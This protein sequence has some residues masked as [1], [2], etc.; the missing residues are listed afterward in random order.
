VAEENAWRG[1]AERLL[2]H[3]Y[4]GGPEIAVEVVLGGIPGDVAAPIPI[5]HSW[6]VVGSSLRR[7]DFGHPAQML[8]VVIDAEGTAASAIEEFAAAAP[9]AGWRPR[10]EQGP[11]RGGFVSG[12][13][14]DARSYE[15]GDV[16]LRVVAIQRPGMPVDIR[17]HANTE[18]IP[19]SRRA[20][21][22]IPEAAAH[23][24]TLRAPPG[25]RLGSGGGSG[26]DDHYQQDATIDTELRVAGLHRH[27]AGQLEAVGWHSL[28]QGGDDRA[29]WSTWALP[30]EQWQGLLLV[31]NAF[32]GRRSTLLL[33]VEA[34][35][36][37]HGDGNSF[38]IVSSM[39]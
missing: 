37:R 31:L 15:R 13:D 30:D 21:H 27:F 3:G 34:A 8:D 7:M 24:P 35:N 2:N 16:V 12:T 32:A 33:R 17:I 6:R 36:H 10:E 5:P 23:L 18:E 20:P 25:T 22:G 1:L 9:S 26:S 19:R 38:G 29:A 28:H 14:G 11:V 4:P 39:L